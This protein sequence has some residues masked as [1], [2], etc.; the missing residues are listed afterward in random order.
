MGN[1]TRLENKG[2]I[3]GEFFCCRIFAGRFL[4]HSKKKSFKK[5]A[6]KKLRSSCKS[7]VYNHYEGIQAKL[8]RKKKSEIQIML[9]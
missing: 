3:S 8:K 6:V 1:K 4:F 7:D 9:S 2:I 5:A